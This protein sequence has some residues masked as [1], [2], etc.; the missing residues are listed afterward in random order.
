MWMLPIVFVWFTLRRGYSRQTRTTVFAYAFAMPAV[1][2]SL[3]LIVWVF[4]LP[5]T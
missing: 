1:S 4:G 2:L 3:H 5:T